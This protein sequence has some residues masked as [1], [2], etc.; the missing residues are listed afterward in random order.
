MQ[1]GKDQE[2]AKLT[3]S[4]TGHERDK[5]VQ[6]LEQALKEMEGRLARTN[7]E[8][9]AKAVENNQLMMQVH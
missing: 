3:A 4:E 2:N 7:S 5:T 1:L 8:L 9:R 6:S